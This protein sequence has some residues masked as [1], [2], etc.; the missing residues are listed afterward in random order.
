MADRDVW[1][2]WLLER[3]FGGDAARRDRMLRSLLPVRDRVLDRAELGPADVVLDVGAGD[4][5]LAFGALE[6]LDPAVEVIISD[7]SDD[8]L[9]TCREAA[10]ALGVEDRCRFVQAAAEDMTVIG[11]GSVD[12]IVARSVL[13]YVADKAAAFAEFF[14]VLRP[15]GRISLSEPIN[16]YFGLRPPPTEWWGGFDVRPV[17]D[18][19]ERVRSVYEAAQP[20]ETSPMTNFDDRD[21]VRL[22]G[23]A[24]FNPVELELKV[25]YTRGESWHSSWGTFMNLAPNPQLPTFAEAM[26]KALSD[27]EAARLVAH[28]RPQLVAGAGVKR[29]AVAFLAGTKPSDTATRR[30]TEAQAES[31]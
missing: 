20:P 30:S 31:E 5:L 21:L 9:G 18:L 16:R 27:D 6:R 1:A 29:S 14:R 7:V 10:A 19:A 8:L 26:A 28:L 25:A 17:L 23:E 15:G 2:S 22:A 13:V 4:G 11:D 3:R 24:G 12:V